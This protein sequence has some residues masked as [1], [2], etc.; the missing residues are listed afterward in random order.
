MVHSTRPVPPQG[1]GL[2]GAQFGPGGAGPTSP[3]GALSRLGAVGERVALAG[4]LRVSTAELQDVVGSIKR[5]VTNIESKLPA[6]WEVVAWFIDVESGRMDISDRGQGTAHLRYD[7]P[8][9]RDGGVHDLLEEAK[10]RDCRFVAA[11]SESTS[12]VARYTYFGTKIE[13][14]LGQRNMELFAADESID[15]AGKKAAKVLMRRINQGVA[16]FHAL[17]VA[18]L[19]WDGMK[20]HTEEGYAVGKPP[21]GYLGVQEPHP[22][23]ARAQRGQKRTRFDVDQERGPAVTQIFAWRVVDELTYWEIANRLNQDLTHYPPPEPTKK[24]TARGFWTLGTVRSILA[25]PKYTGYMVYNRTT[26]RNGVTV[27]PK[28]KFRPTPPDQWIW[29]P[30]PTHTELVTL[31]TFQKAQNVGARLEGSP[32]RNDANPHPATKNT[33]I[34]RGLIRCPCARRMSGTRRA[35]LTYYTCRGPIDAKRQRKPDAN[36]GT[37]YIREDALL[38]AVIATIAQRVFGPDRRRHLDEQRNHQ[39]RQLA[40]QHD[41]SIDRTIQAIADIETRQ[42][43]LATEL[44][45]TSPEHAAWRKT[46]RATFD[47]LETQKVGLVATL[48]ELQA[49]RPVIDDSDPA[50]LDAMPTAQLDLQALPQDLLRRLFDALNL[51]IR[52]Q[53][54]TRAD[55][56]IRLKGDSPDAVAGTGAIPRQ[57]SGS[58]TPM[59]NPPSREMSDSDLGVPLYD[60]EGVG[61]SRES[62]NPGYQLSLGWPHSR[63]SGALGRVFGTTKSN[64]SI[65]RQPPRSGSNHNKIGAR[66]SA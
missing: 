7:L 8:V 63:R 51:E 22:A 5:Q 46:I 12:R 62:T 10:R 50:I 18:E 45:S 56:S 2:A 60:Q 13:Y 29:S 58:S 43:N 23:P 19:A 52:L 26:S 42:A 27:A 6:G 32:A 48:A 41:H 55:L 53:D 66:D 39:P 64:P 65:S 61:N 16:E 35:D 14:E 25:N 20:V 9:P 47:K 1:S 30:N 59:A 4:L 28:K 15:P 40:E 36:H 54:Q 17:N 34:F 21:Y 11:I 37:V 38:P 44:A 24:R 49:T 3:W 57:R 33:Y 31:E